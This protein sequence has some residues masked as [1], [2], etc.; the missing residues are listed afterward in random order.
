VP[1]AIISSRRK[2]EQ[3][4]FPFMLEINRKYNHRLLKE[5]GQDLLAFETSRL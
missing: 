3:H 1:G 5:F 4:P 2:K